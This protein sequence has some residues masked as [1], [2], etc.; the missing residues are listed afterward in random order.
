MNRDPPI[1]TANARTRF[2]PSSSTYAPDKVLA[3]RAQTRRSQLARRVDTLDVRQ[4][5]GRVRTRVRRAGGGGAVGEPIDPF[6]ELAIQGDGDLGLRHGR[7]NYHTREPVTTERFIMASQSVPPSAPAP[8]GFRLQHVQLAIPRGSEDAC[9]RFYVDILGLVE[10]PKPPALA[11]RGGMW[12][13]ADDVEIHLGVEDDFRPAKKAHPA[14]V[15]ANFDAAGNA[16][17]RIRHR[18]SV[19]RWHPRYTTLSHQ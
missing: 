19:G 2:A 11:V 4:R 13:R 1:S 10:V 15:V 3:S 14:F 6:D 16:S 12:L 18:D 17:D 8:F 7:M 5:R 9:R